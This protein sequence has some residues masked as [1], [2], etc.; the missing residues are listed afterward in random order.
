MIFFAY[1]TKTRRARNLRLVTLVK[2]VRTYFIPRSIGHR[3]SEQFAVKICVASSSPN[4]N[5]KY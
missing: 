1:R 5:G 2:Y 3:T 4:F